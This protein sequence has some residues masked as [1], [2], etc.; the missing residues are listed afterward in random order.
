MTFSHFFLLVYF[1]K[2]TFFPLIIRLY[3][4]T[5]L[6][7]HIITTLFSFYY[8]LFLIILHVY[9]LKYFYFYGGANPCEIYLQF[10]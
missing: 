6:F 1:L 8:D 10:N 4:H 5:L 9:F 3:S 2:M 7:S